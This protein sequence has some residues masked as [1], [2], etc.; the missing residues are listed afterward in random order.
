M[1][2]KRLLEADMG[3]VIAPPLERDPTELLQ[4]KPLAPL[5]VDRLIG[6]ARTLQIAFRALQSACRAA[7]SPAEERE[8]EAEVDFIVELAEDVKRVLVALL[9]HVG[10]AAITGDVANQYER[11]AEPLAILKLPEH[12]EDVVRDA[13]R[14]PKLSLQSQ[15]L[16]VA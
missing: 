5:A 11:A 4:H 6:I 16:R 15:P 8:R 12:R 9:S 14:T 13:L 2:V 7:G 3:F 1:K 10:G